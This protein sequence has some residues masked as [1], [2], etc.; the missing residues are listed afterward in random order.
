MV[1][2]KVQ[3]FANRQRSIAKG[4]GRNRLVLEWRSFGSLGKTLRPH[5]P[6]VTRRPELPSSQPTL[7]TER[8]LTLGIQVLVLGFQQM[9]FTP[10]QRQRRSVG[11]KT[12]AAGTS[13]AGEAG[14]QSDSST[15]PR[16]YLCE[17]CDDSDGLSISIHA[18]SPFK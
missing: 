14:C 7:V 1:S 12:N 11:E 2:S 5:G 15:R 13:P 9:V 18:S 6:T 3:F 10:I 17:A 4:R 8:I 16:E